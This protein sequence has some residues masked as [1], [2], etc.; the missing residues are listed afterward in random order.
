M[1]NTI[2][3]AYEAQKQGDKKEVKRLARKYIRES[4]PEKVQNVSS[5]INTAFGLF[6]IFGVL[7]IS[8]GSLWW[9][10]GGVSLYALTFLW[11]LW[12]LKPVSKNFQA[13]VYNYHLGIKGQQK[14]KS[15]L[16]RWVA[17]QKGKQ[18]QINE[19]RG[20]L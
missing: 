16:E 12:Y 8:T 7:S 20:K 3:E 11:S 13:E 9:I 6:F 17:A 1:S 18:G 4:T 2:K 19:A 10:I 15:R 5:A 14:P